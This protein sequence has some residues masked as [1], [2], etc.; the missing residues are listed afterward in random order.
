MKI[1]GYILGY[2]S[3]GIGSE[4]ELGFSGYFLKESVKYRKT[5]NFD[6]VELL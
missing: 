4:S 6:T 1:S 5:G 3:F 2:E